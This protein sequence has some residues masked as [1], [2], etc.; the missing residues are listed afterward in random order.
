MKGFWTILLCLSYLSSLSQG[1]NEPVTFG[2]DTYNMIVYKPAG[3]NSNPTKKYPTI[4]FLPGQGEVGTNPAN[5]YK[6]G[7]NWAIQQ[8]W[9]GEVV[10]GDSTFECI[11]I[12][13]QRPTVS[14]TPDPIIRCIDTAKTRYRMDTMRIY[15]T[16]L[17]LGGQTTIRSFTAQ[18]LS[19]TNYWKFK[20]FKAAWILSQ[21]DN[22][23]T[24]NYSDLYQYA[25]I[26]GRIL[27][28]IGEDDEAGRI[29]A[30]DSTLIGMNNGVPGSGVGREW[31]ASEASSSP[32]VA[33]HGGWNV[34]YNPDH[35]S[36]D[37][38][39]GYAWLLGHSGRPYASAGQ[40]EISTATPSAVLN[41]IVNQYSWGYNG[42]DRTITW[43]QKSGPAS[44]IVTPGTDTTAVNLLGGAGT[45]VFT[46]TSAN[47]SGETASTD[48]T[49]YY[50][51]NNEKFVLKFSKYSNIVL[52]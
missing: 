6:Y 20:Q 27:T 43:T 33:G 49:V 4:F 31:N 9:N 12:S 39:S 34:F 14:G 46:L 28:M 16:C 44:E 26:G 8:G 22:I 35:I 48:V 11:L 10:L 40:N 38:V 45:Y 42:W 36:F 2:G 30:Y 19:A 24:N 21:G 15:M 5:A 13:I 29:A 18:G 32:G 1:T 7:P 23:S 17:S 3:Y 41:G 37:G 51:N 52:H 50:T 47:A 25:G